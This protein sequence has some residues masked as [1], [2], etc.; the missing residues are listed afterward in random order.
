MAGRR[1]VRSLQGEWLLLHLRPSDTAPAGQA[2][3][4]DWI[5]F[6]NRRSSLG[7]RRARYSTM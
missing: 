3:T 1:G 4:R 7:L 6:C 2:A 5:T